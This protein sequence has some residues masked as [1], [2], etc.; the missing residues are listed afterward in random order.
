MQSG[1]PGL[2]QDASESRLCSLRSHPE[3]F[4]FALAAA[5]QSEYCLALTPALSPGRGDTLHPHWKKAP[6]GEVSAAMEIGLPLL[7]GE[8]RGE[9]ERFFPLNFSGLN[10]FRAVHTC[11]SPTSWRHPRRRAANDP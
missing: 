10:Q 3:R 9:G 4:G 5:M 7:G 8:G 2:P 6:A 1:K 11:R